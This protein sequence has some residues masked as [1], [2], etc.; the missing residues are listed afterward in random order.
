MSL[1]CE[2]ISGV[3]KESRPSRV[4]R[5]HYPALFR[6]PRCASPIGHYGRVDRK[7]RRQ[8]ICHVCAHKWFVEPEAADVDFG[9]IRS[10]WVPWSEVSG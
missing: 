2:K 9:G 6:C 3:L 10:V 5:I 4:I 1:S 8:R 7:R